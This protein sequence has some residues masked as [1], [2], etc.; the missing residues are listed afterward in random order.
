MSKVQ[1]LIVTILWII[2]IRFLKQIIPWNLKIM[3]MVDGG[4]VIATVMVVVRMEWNIEERRTRLMRHWNL[5]SY[6][7]KKWC[8]IWSHIFRC[9]QVFLLSIQYVP[10]HYTQTPNSHIS[11]ESSSCWFKFFLWFFPKWG[12]LNLKSK[13]WIA[14]VFKAYQFYVTTIKISVSRNF[15]RNNNI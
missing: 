4:M 2:I 10:I 15:P 8:H 14:V 12:N 13:M 7:L 5:I 11:F 6:W 1:E 3:I 9:F